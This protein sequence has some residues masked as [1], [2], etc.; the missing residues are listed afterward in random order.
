MGFDN[1]VTIL[2]NRITRLDK[3]NPQIPQKEQ[4]IERPGSVPAHTGAGDHLPLSA[5]SSRRLKMPV[6][7]RRAAASSSAVS[8]P[9]R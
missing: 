2:Y 6:K 4:E 8:L 7:R 5:S 1:L 9:L 3:S